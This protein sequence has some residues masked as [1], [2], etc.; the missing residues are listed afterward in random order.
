MTIYHSFKPTYLYIKLHTVTGMRYFGKTVKSNVDSYYG[1]GK[2][3][4]NH[5]KTHGKA[6]VITE[7]KQLFTDQDDLVSTA[8]RMSKELD[9]LNSPNWANLIEENGLD[10]TP[11]GVV[12][13]EEHRK[14]I[15]KGSLGKKMSDEARS[16]MRAA[17]I[18]KKLPPETV[19]KMRQSRKGV[20]RPPHVIEAMAKGRRGKPR[21]WVSAY[22]AARRAEKPLKPKPAANK[23]RPSVSVANRIRWE[24]WR[25]D[26]QAQLEKDQTENIVA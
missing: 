23:A 8:L 2:Y 21:P 24:K 4:R 9:I 13:T 14:N 20:P 3:W 26:R 15:S 22:W 11:V 17:N 12:F 5:I 16:K 10:G 1:S 25:Q 7:W 18:G 6:H 19:E